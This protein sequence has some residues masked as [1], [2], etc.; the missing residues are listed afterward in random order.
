MLQQSILGGTGNPIAEPLTLA[1]PGSFSVPP[2]EVKHHGNHGKLTSLQRKLYGVGG[3]HLILA[4]DDRPRIRLQR[5]CFR[6]MGEEGAQMVDLTRGSSIM[7]AAQLLVALVLAILAMITFGE[8]GIDTEHAYSLGSGRAGPEPSLDMSIMVRAEPTETMLDPAF[9]NF[10]GL[11]LNLSVPRDAA[12]CSGDTTGAERRAELHSTLSCIAPQC[13]EF[14]GQ[15]PNWGATLKKFGSRGIWKPPQPLH[16]KRQRVTG[17]QCPEADPP[18]QRDSSADWVAFAHGECFAQLEDGEAGSALGDTEHSLVVPRICTPA[19]YCVD[20]SSND[21]HWL[22][23]RLVSYLSFVV[24]GVAQRWLLVAVT[25]YPARGRKK[26]LENVLEPDVWQDEARHK[27]AIEKESRKLCLR[28]WPPIVLFLIVSAIVW[29]E[30]VALPTESDGRAD[31][32]HWWR[33]LPRLLLVLVEDAFPIANVAATA[34]LLGTKCVVVKARMK[35]LLRDVVALPP[36]LAT[37]KA[38]D[39]PVGP[40]RP[41][42]SGSGAAGA[43]AQQLPTQTLQLQLE[44]VGLLQKIGEVQQEVQRLSEV[45]TRVLLVQCLLTG[46]LLASCIS[47]LLHQEGLSLINQRDLAKDKSAHVV[48]FVNTA[49]LLWALLLSFNKVVTL[50]SYFES[51]PTRLSRESAFTLEHR[52]HFAEEYRRLELWLNVP[53]VGEVTKGTRFRALLG[54]AGF[55]LTAISWQQDYSSSGSIVG[56]G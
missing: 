45:W 1:S 37:G 22:T 10:S 13:L 49:P 2:Q 56:I 20:E 17:W 15:N 21:R 36:E 7:L 23:F 51:I 4:D 43:L 34:L 54:F 41:A 29:P 25:R 38:L 48:A 42:A 19:F 53:L 3:G 47:T 8:G 40:R 6:N 33:R 28:I 26:V 18:S 27:E 5:R 46:A 39:H 9:A 14:F 35:E 55:I 12:C 50:N 31:P 24:M 11:G 52:C 30:V 44:P 16:L 32:R